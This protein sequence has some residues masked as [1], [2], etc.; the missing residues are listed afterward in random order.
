MTTKK[1]WCHYVGRDGNTPKRRSIELTN[2]GDLIPTIGDN[3]N[4]ETPLWYEEDEDQYRQRYF[5]VYAQLSDKVATYAACFSAS[6]NAFEFMTK[7]EEQMDA[8]Y[9]KELNKY[10][11]EFP[12]LSEER[13]EK[14][15][16]Y[17]GK[18]L[19]SH[20][21]YRRQCMEKLKAYQDYTNVLLKGAWVMG[22]TVRAYE[23]TGSPYLPVI[24]ELRRRGLELRA[25]QNRKREEERR[26]IAE[27]EAKRKAEEEA[28]EYERLTGEAIKC[29]N[30]KSISGEDVVELCRRYG[31]NVHLRTV[32]NLQQVVRVINGRDRNCQYY[33]IRGKRKPVL[34]GCYTAAQQLYDYLQTHDVA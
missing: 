9:E 7:T 20:K 14:E 13:K 8:E 12:K 31:I 19:K 4:C 5:Y 18:T 24:Q 30:G 34:D 28:K 33:Q 21:E 1:F 27:E 26:R 6:S 10:F 15:R 22:C 11:A 23:D 2:L 3:M 25:E 29:K 17:R 32:H 16:E